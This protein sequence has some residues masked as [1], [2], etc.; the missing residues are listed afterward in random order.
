MYV[1]MYMYLD[2]QIQLYT[3]CEIGMYYFIRPHPDPVRNTF[4]VFLTADM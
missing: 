3:V 4:Q 2:A 1:C